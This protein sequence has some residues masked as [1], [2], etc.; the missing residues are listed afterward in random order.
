MLGGERAADLLS[1]ALR[2]GHEAEPELPQWVK[3]GDYMFP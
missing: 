2:D 1:A 3:D